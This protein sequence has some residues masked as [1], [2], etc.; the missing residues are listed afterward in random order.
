MPNRNTSSQNYTHWILNVSLKEPQ[1]FV[2]K[3]FSAV[4]LLIFKYR[5][6]NISVSVT[7]ISAVADPEV[8][9]ADKIPLLTIG[10]VQLL[11]RET[12]N[13]IAPTL[14]PANSPDLNP[15]ITRLG[16]SC[17]SM[18]TTDEV[19]SDRRVGTLQRDDHQ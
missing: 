4:E 5:R 8:I 1:N 10:H 6:Q 17:R 18:C 3:Y 13:F 11:T 14:W 9:F 12:P 15:E 2:R 19:A 7:L 16:G